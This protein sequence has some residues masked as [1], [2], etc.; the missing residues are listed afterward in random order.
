MPDSGDAWPLVYNPASRF[1][2]GER[3]LAKARAALTRHGI[4]TDPRP[5]RKPGDARERVLEAVDEGHAR[6]A[7]LGGDGTLSEAADGVLASGEDVALGLLPGGTGNSLLRCWKLE[8]LDA[9]AA[10]LASGRER[11]IDAMRLTWD[12]ADAQGALHAR[13][14]RY[15]LDNLATGFGALAGAAANQRFKG[16]GESAYTR[17]VLY[18]MRRLTAPRTRLVLDGETLDEDLVFVSVANAPHTGGRMLIA[19]DASPEDGMLD[20]LALRRVTKTKLLRLFPRIFDGSHIGKP[21]VFS[22][23]SASVRIEPAEPSPLLGDGEL[24]GATP[25]DV[26]VVPKALRVRL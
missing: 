9:A 19:P 26:R 4:A 5:T 24:F 20:V 13:E 7:V 16:W 25:V 11:R 8:G 22:A 23:R 2:K 17:A 12:G 6:I 15:L 10:A 21:E 1:G 3:M 14:P 18:Q